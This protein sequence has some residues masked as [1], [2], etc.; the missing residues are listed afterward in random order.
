MQR[1][2]T[3]VKCLLALSP[4]SILL[5]EASADGTDLLWTVPYILSALVHGQFRDRGMRM[6]VDGRDLSE[7]E[8]KERGY[9]IDLQEG[10]VEVRI[11]LGAHGGH[12]KVYK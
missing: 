8:H 2:S 4:F 9:K 6:E 5:D 11:P 10:T 12:V 1:L 7:S 3:R